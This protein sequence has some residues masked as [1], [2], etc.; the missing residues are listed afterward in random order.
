MVYPVIEEEDDGDDEEETRREDEV[1]GI[2]RT[3][4]L[5]QSG[6]IVCTNWAIIVFLLYIVYNPP[7]SYYYG[8]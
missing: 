3:S 8:I 2:D 1:R 4:D 7:Q 6:M 5:S